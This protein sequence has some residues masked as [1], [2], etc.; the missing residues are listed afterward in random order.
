[1][2]VVLPIVYVEISSAYIEILQFWV[3][4]MLWYSIEKNNGDKIEHW[5]TPQL[6]FLVYDRT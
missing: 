4:G 1:M 2:A 3:I 5:G 6:A